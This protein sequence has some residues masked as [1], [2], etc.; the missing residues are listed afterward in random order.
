M[1]GQKC[2]FISDKKTEITEELKAVLSSAAN[3]L[4]LFKDT[5]DTTT[6]VV[7]PPSGL[8]LYHSYNAHISTLL[9]YAELADAGVYDRFAKQL[10]KVKTVDKKKATIYTALLGKTVAESTRVAMGIEAPPPTDSPAQLAIAPG[11]TDASVSPLEDVPHAGPSQTNAAA[12]PGPSTAARRRVP[13]KRVP[14][15]VFKSPSKRPAPAVVH[16]EG[17]DEMSGSEKDAEG[18]PEGV[19]SPLTPLRDMEGNA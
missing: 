15:L 1:R 16:D 14:D 8:L 5:M 6:G 12:G 9:S 17:S 13:S 4:T 10:V 18:E 19:G 3:L 7:S 11:H 2:S